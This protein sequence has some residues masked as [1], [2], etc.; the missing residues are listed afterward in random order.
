MGSIA[1]QA[2]RDRRPAL[3]GLRHERKRLLKRTG[4]PVEVTPAQPH[5]DA[6]RLALDREHRCACHCRRKRLGAPEAGIP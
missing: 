4:L 6:A 3:C 1:K 5:L 2:D